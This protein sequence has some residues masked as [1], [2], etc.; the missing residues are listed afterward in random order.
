MV[1][2]EQTILDT[3]E[4]V[5]FENR[6]VLKVGNNNPA[7]KNPQ[8]PMGPDLMMQ[9][10][11]AD[12]SMGGEPGIEDPMAMGGVP[13]ENGGM[14][15]SFDSNFDA[16]VQA[17][18]ETDPEKYIQQ[19]TGK[20]SQ[21]LNSFNNE[22]GGDTSINKYVASMIIKAACKNL[23]EKDKKELIE[24]IN[25]ASSDDEDMPSDSEMGNEGGEDMEQMNEM[26]Y[27]KA[28]LKEMLTPSKSEVSS[29]NDSKVKSAEK[30]NLKGPWAPKKFKK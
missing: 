4:R 22:N 10:P 11:S 25:T 6:K 28:Q 21:K 1:I 5:I 9:Q 27:T 14:P 15:S 12:P 29:D 24:K 23:D 17:D 20:L 19:L 7:Q 26:V 3:I 16:G 30:N 2:K 13:D 8:V 18:E